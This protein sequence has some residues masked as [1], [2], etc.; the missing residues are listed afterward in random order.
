M[1]S[2][3]LNKVSSRN[4]GANNSRPAGMVANKAA[5][6]SVLESLRNKYAA[7]TATAIIH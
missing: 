1:N 4:S 7:S 6:M 2:Q 3:N 5:A